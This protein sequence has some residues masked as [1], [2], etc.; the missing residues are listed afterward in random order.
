MGRA[1]AR[2]DFEVQ[3]AARRAVPNG[4]VLAQQVSPGNLG[5]MRVVRVRPSQRRTQPLDVL[6]RGP[7]E[8]VEALGRA[9]H[10]VE[11]HGG[12]ADEDV[13]QA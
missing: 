8:Q 5:D 9:H 3:V 2:E 7:D 1:E 12:R 13:L 6:G 4:G 11:T 10:A